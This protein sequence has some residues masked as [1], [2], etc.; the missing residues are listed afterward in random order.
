ME[1]RR[2]VARLDPHEIIEQMSDLV[3]ERLDSC[4]VTRD[5]ILDGL[6]NKLAVR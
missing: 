1:V 6:Q 5:R 2:V 3:V 4:L